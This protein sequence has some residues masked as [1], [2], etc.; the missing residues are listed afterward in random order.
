[1]SSRH[2]FFSPGCSIFRSREKGPRCHSLAEQACSCLNL[3]Q[4][5]LY[6]S[7][8]ST[9]IRL[10]Q[11]CAS[12]IEGKDSVEK[13]GISSYHSPNTLT[14]FVIDSSAILKLQFFGDLF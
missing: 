12:P 8:H 3:N 5:D 7:R 14:R 1:M 11:V 10:N 4:A 6:S 9:T 2:P 13:Q